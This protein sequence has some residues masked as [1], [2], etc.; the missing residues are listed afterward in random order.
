MVSNIGFCIAGREWKRWY[1][2]SYAYIII[3][4]WLGVIKF[5]RM[6][7]PLRTFNHI[8][9]ASIVDIWK[10]CLFALFWLF[11]VSSA[12]SFTEDRQH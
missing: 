3:A 2:I 5:S 9:V 6:F 1:D 4:L 12:I 8:M 11:A 10:F 7:Y